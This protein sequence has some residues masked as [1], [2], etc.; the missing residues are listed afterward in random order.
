MGTMSV[1]TPIAKSTKPLWNMSLL[2][3]LFTIIVVLQAC[4]INAK[5]LHN[6]LT[7][8]D[9]IDIDRIDESNK[10]RSARDL[11]EKAFIEDE[12]QPVDEN[13]ATDEGSWL[14]QSV[15]R[16]RR[17]LGRLFGSEGA[18][19]K[20]PHKHHKKRAE[21]TEAAAKRA[22][23][24]GR[25]KGHHDGAKLN[26]KSKK[27]HKLNDLNKHKKR[28]L[29][30]DD[31]E[32]SGNPIDDDEPEDFGETDLWEGLIT[33]DVPWEDAFE[34]KL[35]SEYANLQRQLESAF[36]D[37]FGEEFDVNYNDYAL[38]VALMSVRRTDNMYKIHCIFQMDLPESLNTFGEKLKEQLE[39][40][41][42]LGDLGAS[43]D[44]HYYFRRVREIRDPME[45][46]TEIDPYANPESENPYGGAT[47]YG[48]DNDP[49][50][51]DPYAN[52]NTGGYADPNAR[53]YPD[54]NAGSYPD[55]NAGGYS[56]PNAGGYDGYDQERDP[57]AGGYD[58]Y[59]QGR[60]PNTGY[61]Q[62]RDPNAGGYGG[63]DQGRDPN[64]GGYGGYDQERDPHAYDQENYPNGNEYGHEDENNAPTTSS[65]GTPTVHD[66]DRYPEGD[67]LCRNGETIPCSER[68]DNKFDCSDDTDEEADMCDAVLAREDD[69][70]PAEGN[71]HLDEDHR[72]PETNTY[73]S[74]NSDD[75]REDHPS[76]HQ[77]NP[78]VSTIADCRSN[79]DAQFMCANR[80]TMP[81]YVV[82]DGTPHCSDGSDENPNECPDNN[83]GNRDQANEHEVFDCIANPDGNFMCSNGEVIPCYLRCDGVDHC[84][85]S[86]DETVKECPA[87]TS[88]DREGSWGTPTPR[89]YDSNGFDFSHPIEY[90]NPGTDTRIHDPADRYD[91][92][93]EASGEEGYNPATET[94]PVYTNR[95]GGCRGDTTY[96]CFH[97]GTV[98]CEE[99]VCDGT[100]NCPDG[101]DEEDCG[102]NEEEYPPYEKV[103][104]ANEFKCDD[105]CLPKDYLCNGFT[106]CHDGTD[107]RDCP[108]KE[109][110]SSEFK[111]RN[112]MC[113]DAS[114]RC[115]GYKDC[116]DNDDEDERCPV[117]CSNDQYLCR[118]GITCISEGIMCDGTEDCVDGDD[119]EHCDSSGDNR[120][121]GDDNEDEE[122]CRYNEFR[123][124]NG[125]CILYREVCDNIYDC[126][127][128]SD[129]KDCDL[130]DIDRNIFDE[131][132]I[133]RQYGEHHNRPTEAPPKRPGSLHELDEQD[134]YYYR[135]PPSYYHKANDNNPCTSSQFRCGNNVCI[136]IHLRCDG[137]YHCNDLTDELSCDGNQAQYNRPVT[138]N[139][140]ANVVRTTTPTP[141]RN[142]THW[143][144]PAPSTTSQTSTTIRTTLTTP[145]STKKSCLNSEFMCEN[146]DCLALEAV[147]DG[148]GDCRRYD[149]ESY[150]LCNCDTDKFKC[151]RGGGCL[152]KTQVCDGRPQCRDGSDEMNCR[153]CER[154]FFKC[155]NTC[156][157]WI[158]SCDGKIDC[159]DGI[160][161]QGC[162]DRG[163]RNDINNFLSCQLDQ[164]TCHNFECINS[165][166][167]CDGRPDCSDASDESPILC[168]L[169]VASVLTPDD[170]DSNQ[171]FC[172]DDCHDKSIRCNGKYECADRSD[173]VDCHTPYPPHRPPTYP[174]PQHTCSDGKCYSESERCD[175]T[176]QCD[177]G[178]DEL[179][180]CAADQFRCR[181]GDCV[182]GYAHCN[183]HRECMDGSDEDDCTDPALPT[184]RCLPSQ[185]RCDN[186]QCITA[187][188]RCN[189]YVDCADSSDERYCP[190]SPATAAPQL[191]L[192]T[193]PDNQVIK[194]SREVIFRCRD[195]GMLRAK[196]RWT[197]PGGRPLPIGSRDK[198]GRLE[199]PNIR[200]EDSGTYIC[201]AVGYPRH[202]SGQQVSVQ[203]TVEKYN[204]RD[205]R[206]PSAC[207]AAQATCMNGECI[208]KSQICDGIPHC[209][210]GSDEHSCSQGRK[211]QPNQFMCRNSKCVDRVWRCDGEN[212]CGDNSDEESCDPEPSGAPCRYDEFQ[213]R[214]GHCIPK[215][216]QCDDTNDC[217][218]GSDEIGCMAPDKIRDPPPTQNL[219]TGDSLNLT[220]V[221]VGTPTPVIVWRLNWGHVPEKCVSKSYS[222]T[223]TLFCPDMQFGDSGAYSC[224]I[225]NSKGSKFTTDTIV[226]VDSGIP[227]GV[228]SSGSFNSGAHRQE[229][230]LN[231]FCFGIT[232]SC[233]SSNLFIS[234]IQ[235]PITS[236]RVV[237]VELSPYRSIV[238]NDA[239]SSGIMNL[240]HGVQF[241]ASDVQYGGSSS[242]YLALPQDFMGNQ[243]KS[244]GGYVKY[245]VRFDAS[246]Q[247]TRNP[248]VIMTGNG[249]TLTYRSRN[250]PQPNFVNHME[251]PLSAGN[252]MKP[253]GRSATREEIM[254]ILSNVDNLL[255]RLSY[256]EATE[257][258]VEV[259]NIMMN[260]AGPHDQG[261]GPANLVEQCSC[262]V[263]Y[264]GDSCESC[265]PGYVRQSGGAWLG[266]C[267]PFKPE[268]CPTGTYGDP[269]RGIPCR[270]CPCPQTGSNNFASGCS[271]G[272]DNE[273]TCNCN[274]GYT[275]RRCESCAPGYEGNP[276]A[277]GGR[278]YPV[279]DDNCNSEGTYS[280]L[281]NNT[282]E[283]KSLVSGPRCDTCMPGSYHLNSFTYTGCIECFCSGL[284]VNCGSSSWNRD[285]IT[286][287]FG[288]SRAP[289]GFT[290]IRNYNTDEPSPVDFALTDTSLTFRE[291]PTS[292]PL[293][294]SLPAQFLGNQITAYGGKLSYNLSYNPMPGG[295]MSRSTTPD[296]VIKSGE[297]LTIIHYRRGGFNPSEPNSYSIPMIES[298]WHRSD[299]QSVNRQHL[300][301]ALSKIDAIY[302][303]ATY[304]TSTKDG[305]LT[306]VSM[307]IATPSSSSGVRAWEVEECR[308]PMGYVG[309]SCER[310]APGFKRN[311][312]AGLYLGLCEPCECNGHS[313]QCDGETG[314]CLNCADNTEGEMC[315]R[316]AYG[317]TG[318]ATG[319]TPYDCQPGSGPY[320]QPPPHP[321]PQP[322]PH[323]QPRPEPGNQTTCYHCNEAGTAS[324]GDD[325]C[326]CKPNAQGSRCDQC[327]PGTYGLSSKNPDGCEECF[328]S[329]KSSTCRSA[330]LYRQLIP[331]DFLSNKPLYTDE[332]GLVAD[333]E[334][335]SF[336]IARNE[337]TYSYTSYTPK[338]WSLRGSVL[339]NQLY[340]YGGELSYQLNVDSYGHYE[341]GN[342]VILI[343]NGMKLIWSRPASEQENTEYSIR[344]HEDENW[345]TIQRGAMERA[346][347]V[348]FMNV[349][350]NLEHILI[351]A[352]PKI[353]TTRTAISD[354][355][356]ESA[357]ETPQ[358]GATH[359]VDIELCTCPP[360]YTGSSCESCAA[361]HYRD[362]YGNC[363]A[364]PCQEDTTSSCSLD[365][366]GYVKCQCMSGYTGDRCQNQV[367]PIYET[368]PEMICDL[369]K[370]FCC[371]GY[372]FHIEPNQTIS[373]NETLL[374]YRGKEYIGNIT[375]LRYG[376]KDY[377][378][379][380]APSPTPDG[381]SDM[382]YKTQ[383]KV[384]IAP[385]EITI[386][387]V[388]GSLTLSCTGYMVYTGS[389]VIV[390][391]YKLEGNMP[392]NWDQDS[393]VL[394]LYDLQLYDSGTYICQAR[395]NQTQ[396][397]YEDQIT[398]TITESA[399]RS[400]PRIEN[401][402]S[403]HTFPEFTP[404][405]INCNAV[406]NPTPVVTWTR[407]NGQV[408]SEVRVEGG[409][410]IF[411]RPRK[412]DE[413]SYRCRAENG[414]GS[415]A[416]QYTQVYVETS[417]VQPPPPP[418][419]LVYI[420]PP[421]FSGESGELV[422]LTCNPISNIVLK[423]EWTK[424]GYPIYRQHNLIISGN[425][426]EIHESSPRDSG[427]YTCIGIDIR[428]RR[429]YTSDAHVII[430]DGGRQ[431][432]VPP[433][434][435]VGTPP[436]VRA[437]SEEN[438]VVQGRD[439]SV[440][441]EASGNPRPTIRWTK[442]HE[443][444]GD[445]VHQNGNVL[446]IT[447]ARPDNRGI[448]LCIAE[449]E[450]G[451]DQ[452]STFIDIEPRESPTVDVDPKEPQVIMVGGQGMLYCT[453]TGIPSPRV[454]WTRV[455]GQPL[456][457]RH[458]MQHS[459]PGYI[460][461]NEVSLADAGEYKCEAENEVGKVSSTVSIRVIEAPA[462]T[463]QPNNEILSVTEG[464]E[465]KIICSATGTPNPSVRWIKEG[466]DSYGFSHAAEQYNEA[467][468]EINRVTMQDAKIYKCIASNEAGPDERYVVLDV[469]RR[470]GDAPD[471]SDVDRHPYAPPPY[472]RPP[473]QPQP[474]PYYPRPQPQPQPQPRPE[475]VYE[476]KLGD[477]VTLTCELGSAFETRWERVD[478]RPLPSNSYFDRNS[479]FIQHVTENNAGKYRCN[480]LDDRGAIITF[481]LA[482]LV[483]IPIPHITLH[484]QM[485][486]HVNVNS[487]VTITCNVEGAQPM[488][489]S[490]HTE[491][492]RPLPSSVS[493]DGPYLRFYDIAPGH[494]GR[495]Y[496]SASNHYGNATEMAEV[497]VNRGQSFDLQPQSKHYQLNEGETV[498]MLCDVESRLPIRGEIHYTW[499]REDN[500]PLPINAITRN[501]E[502]V[503]N[504]V[505]K[506]DEGRYICESYTANGPSPPSYADLLV[507]RGHSVND[508]PCMVLY[509]CT[510]Y[511]PL[512]IIKTKPLT[513]ATAP[514][515]LP[516][517]PP[518]AM[519]A[520]GRSSYT[521]QPSD[522][523]CVSHPHTCVAK[524]MV[525][526]GIHDCTDHSDEFNCTRDQTSAYKRWKKHYYQ[527]VNPGPM[528]RIKRKYPLMAKIVPAHHG[529]SRQ[530]LPP[531]P[532]YGRGVYESKQRAGVRHMPP[533]YYPPPA[534]YHPSTTPRPRDYSLKLDQ[535][536]SNLR[537][538]EST[539]VECYSSDN[540]YTDVV[541]ERADGK[542]LPLHI[543]QI[544]N[545]LIIN[546]VTPA[547]AGNYLCKCKT[548]KG[549][550]YTTSYELAIEANAHEWKHPKIEHADVG[551]KVKLHCNA[552]QSHMS[553]SYRWSRQYG[554]MQMGT[555][556]L[557]DT[558]SLENVQANDAGTYVCTATTPNGDSI[559]YPTILVVT[560]AIPQFHQD[561]ISYMSFPTLR[562]SYVKFNFDITFRPEKGNG[563]LLF[564]GQKR[565]NGD[566]ISL[567]LND[568]YPEFRFD[569]DG[570]TMIVRGEQALDLNEWHTIRVH[571]F[572]RDGYMQVD[573][574][575]P[576]AFPTLSASSSLDLAEDLYLG[577][578]PSWDILPEDA[579]GEESGFV[580]C[581]SR[582]TLQ[583]SIIELMKEAKMK[584]GISAC[585]PCD[586][587]PCS[588]NGICMESQTEMAYTCICQQGWTGRHCAVEGTQCTPGICGTGRCENT[589]TGM[590]CLCPL[591]KTGDRCQY[592]EHL[593]ENSLAFKTNSFAAYGTPRASKLNIKFQV[594]PNTLEDAVLLYA[595]ESRLPS[596]DYVAVVLRNKHVELIINTGARLKPVVVRSLHPLPAN[597]WTEIEIARR[598]GEGILRVGSDPEQ[599][600]KASGAARTLYI[601]TPMYIGGYDHEKITLNRDVNIT[602]GFDG[603]ISSLYEG[604]KHLNLIADIQDAANIQN[605]GEINEID[606]N[607]TFDN[608]H[609]N[610]IEK[611]ACSTDPCENGG[612][613]IVE[614]EEAMCLC[615]I[616]FAG[617]HCEDHISLQF[618][619]NFHGNGYL[620]LNRTQFDEAV[621]QKFSSAAMVF[622]TTAPDGLLLWWG[623]PKGEAYTGQDFMA[624][625][626]VD[627]IAE[628][629]FRL[630]GEEAVIRNPDKR[631]DDGLRHILLIKRT[632]NTAILE[633]DHILYAD[634]IQDT[635]KQTMSLPGHVFIG[636]APNLES[637]TGGR[638]KHHFNGCVRVVEGETSGIIEVGKV[639]ISGNNVDTCPTADEDVDFDGTEPP[640]V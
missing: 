244:Y 132:E 57:N 385:P 592:I 598:F 422:R 511:K 124:D 574:E 272:P 225:I 180:C 158:L 210:D 240:R 40:F 558:L 309:P 130:Q 222:G 546:H 372:K 156:V 389:P 332:E 199:I 485:P 264:S 623:Q 2:W 388:G 241:R 286:S 175:G 37:W 229:E 285:Q 118:D 174:C 578:V 493:I 455:D 503:I 294:W 607:E 10:L 103:C 471:D 176:S 591:N 157:N 594:R 368:P 300:L 351:R 327:R 88:H 209:S 434:P 582:L 577:G 242:P 523:K 179:D 43:A 453:A 181:N 431:P 230:C 76:V 444:L 482:E 49:H 448:Y 134:Y 129:E 92:G 5:D 456:S 559:D 400:P 589:E 227:G 204:P 580:G 616:G 383:I 632:D 359:A 373:P 405:E 301:M 571:R 451:T 86:S 206:L 162:D 182:S 170:C 12:L 67:F 69:D 278:C 101:E 288:R 133:I 290:L 420:E 520:A 145:A 233:K 226:S 557:S 135:P 126:S 185:F 572:R 208:D 414:E 186:G 387:P 517:P 55:P 424:D 296:V 348:D 110:S 584:E 26:G 542:P 198:D 360:G 486:M 519:T 465:V 167:K 435:G 478:G 172:D 346:S 311:P 59:D 450:A 566:Y 315:E 527:H 496:C 621:E 266:R 131:D 178:A 191:N 271:L 159:E 476:T 183:G 189:G 423:Y 604:Q 123:C 127:D 308:C 75:R 267:V 588:N 516:P 51:N 90:D 122:Y 63:Y 109:C 297:D 81:C 551:S 406:G 466:A 597:K 521:C 639:A 445:N 72:W 320:P 469:K 539:E 508:I 34:D 29:F 65:A 100:E 255:V 27:L 54:P 428:G 535:Q 284:P 96:T 302:I 89:P 622:S 548:D 68:C 106:E 339:G 530:M 415:P 504:S 614:N 194:E 501:N 28:Q 629:A 262:P 533:S 333:T 104:S 491:N 619:A 188:G 235:P 30:G 44:N 334:N 50:D 413:G 291:L 474:R 635:G 363:V 438:M 538:G 212:D 342:D 440:T 321:Y 586:S 305:T 397:V 441:C 216:F 338:Y 8:E 195:E 362:N 168:N 488:S 112:G 326:Y 95:P 419:E 489:V 599:K 425:T 161:E 399:R 111:C 543:K 563:L 579:I 529:S 140:P 606:Q 295:L 163:I 554:Q 120:R 218:D 187:Y 371:N 24:E 552:E 239:P 386:V 522:F 370:G 316:C 38:R 427:T 590:E 331:V 73:D 545:R 142:Y 214:S 452:T 217:R 155:N 626:I 449:N 234:T 102:R 369:P 480:A 42:N 33:V 628:F 23:G 19:E 550:L 421:S 177:D 149:D 390:N 248:D 160:D 312:E 349:L 483:Y 340:S 97:T 490:W 576:I 139:A 41:E 56:H 18:T 426:L 21:R 515:S 555:D 620:E 494:A 429:N 528:R 498:H 236:H 71:N 518:P 231:C 556:I 147:C 532:Q 213:C 634:E 223:G 237:N 232:K 20:K 403:Y 99:Q 173:E 526:D 377:E 637:F 611:N 289:H 514:V 512:R 481:H 93:M 352:T 627:G 497:I 128:Y 460:V 418:R 94:S 220:C 263:G 275:G 184:Q 603:C 77:E 105:R 318:D 446:R 470:R 79:P 355:I 117:V 443:S 487:D 107:E 379:E 541:W 85:D 354:V 618:D 537:V 1:R 567:S 367:G 500:Q 246:G 601:K 547:D 61:D 254:M 153:V 193:Y 381:G 561:P 506:Q 108:E 249:F 196:V 121:I 404:S 281:P 150:G 62:E 224:E 136:P 7:F 277:P 341:P 247:P 171:F 165:S 310:C 273:V 137:F 613:C 568:N 322:H 336:D 31:N 324:C 114:R 335:L 366:R 463:L 141:R 343:G 575:H 314:V 540:S 412:S 53:S 257:R 380:P 143:T 306:H 60:D 119:E 36:L 459:D 64:A 299:G 215:S 46:H 384:S 407:V 374:I 256:V 432:I 638:Y 279:P 583:D 544:G 411:E 78:Y 6:D 203:L 17:E 32:G 442:V 280:V 347:R 58:G 251:I 573:G 74:D 608:E 303:K 325:Y 564:N 408:S 510:D 402:P 190:D 617:K 596:G 14:V 16:V 292:E 600:A 524:H 344:L 151:L 479:L 282:C 593:N 276:L 260:T 258:E 454:Q 115:D 319:G 394:R 581:I 484:P 252:W 202:V 631:V 464:D 562:D 11:D 113:I 462:I 396:R 475:N 138:E 317:F 146:G 376:C 337:Y 270:E 505:R 9:T 144:R 219:K 612:T 243:L 45:H 274:E 98:I 164:F 458:Q 205:D 298:A 250:A 207:S 356:L 378:T 605:C 238:I 640:V 35:S 587:Q 495:Y 625:A 416:E 393:G 430:E 473:P 409:R 569:L 154:G 353:P 358:P 83:N 382:E 433:R 313:T 82:C 265:A 602:Q 200:V 610:N 630:N 357:V 361:M 395:N 13:E 304:T 228:C 375:K 345:H 52:S 549:D 221:G 565:G 560:G 391:W 507:K 437:L 513:S 461:I 4:G 259:T 417:S 87:E 80:E 307:D 499:R 492:N 525:C 22:T 293:Y 166:L 48:H 570:K 253:D 477:N 439:F 66:C 350:S 330:S 70:E 609:A 467:V 328:C 91:G 197:R 636:G 531:K 245:D 148:I 364:C 268:L 192:K 472:N 169:Q 457:H 47:N 287:S 436:V 261:L 401:L 25:K 323:P 502:L 509:I 84:T 283:C 553:P 116:P 211:C 125:Q 15:K 3:K 152:P 329:H 624:L 447:S 398:I 269:R 39:L 585:K 534:I 392:F 201:E 615:S 633:L 410:L 595:A 468:L 536:H 365:D